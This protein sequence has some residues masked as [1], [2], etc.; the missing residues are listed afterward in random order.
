MI[1]KD[2]VPNRTKN[3]YMGENRKRRFPAG[4][5]SAWREKLADSKIAKEAWGHRTHGG[6]LMAVSSPVLAVPKV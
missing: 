3:I 1:N 6:V 5:K 4:A 2:S